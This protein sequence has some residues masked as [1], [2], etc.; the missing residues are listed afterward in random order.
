LDTPKP[1]WNEVER[2]VVEA[3]RLAAPKRL[4]AQLG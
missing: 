2:L 3:Y 4:V 1:D